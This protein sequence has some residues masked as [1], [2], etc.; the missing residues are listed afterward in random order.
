M[1]LW[2]VLNIADKHD[3]GKRCVRKHEFVNI[4]LL[5]YGIIGLLPTKHD[6]CL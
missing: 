2:F 5:L 4:F 3:F 1:S 6:I